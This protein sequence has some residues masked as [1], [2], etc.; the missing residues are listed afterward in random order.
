M[1]EED[2][3][4]LSAL[5]HADGEGLPRQDVDRILNPLSELLTVLQLETLILIDNFKQV[6]KGSIILSLQITSH[7]PRHRNSF[8]GCRAT[9]IAL[10]SR[11]PSSFLLLP[12]QV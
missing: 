9:S 8:F 11:N 12:G 6:S 7:M 5:F 3:D 4:A 2:L 10:S 1:I